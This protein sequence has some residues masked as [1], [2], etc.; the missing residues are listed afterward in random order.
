MILPA[1]SGDESGTVLT[2][3][4]NHFS[5]SVPMRGRVTRRKNDFSAG[6]AY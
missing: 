5:D 2:P 6:S 1:Q 3:L 4:R